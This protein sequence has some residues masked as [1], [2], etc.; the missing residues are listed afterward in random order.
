MDIMDVMMAKALSGGGGG[1]GGTGGGDVYVV[2]FM[3]TAPTGGSTEYTD[4]TANHT[5]EEA[6]AAYDAGK[7]VIFE[8]GEPE[9]DWHGLRCIAS[10]D[11][12]YLAGIAWSYVSR[13]PGS[14]QCTFRAVNYYL[15][16]EGPAMEDFMCVINSDS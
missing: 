8:L 15:E 4:V 5:L 10:N 3:G 9:S 11:G 2:T 14:D 13:Y 7:L 12:G 1:G 16:N 6:M